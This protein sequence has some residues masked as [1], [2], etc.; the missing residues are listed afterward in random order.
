MGPF[1]SA[2]ARTNL[3]KLTL[4]II[5]PGIRIDSARVRLRVSRRVVRAIKKEQIRQLPYT[6]GKHTAQLAEIASLRTLR[7]EILVSPDL[8]LVWWLRNR[9]GGSSTLT[10]KEFNQAIASIKL[11]VAEARRATGPAEILE[12]VT[13]VLDQDERTRF[14][15]GV[16][17][18]LELN[19]QSSVAERLAAALDQQDSPSRPS[20]SLL[21][22]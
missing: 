22:D 9:C 10:E 7:D 15:R 20:Q 19:G 5:H 2:T 18:I 12:E 17:G 21:R 1:Q 14:F 11:T 6:T 4:V 13:H 3:R 8:T 16:C